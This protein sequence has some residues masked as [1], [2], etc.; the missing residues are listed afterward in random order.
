MNCEKCSNPINPSIDP[1]ISV[2]EY[3]Q[4]AKDTDVDARVCSW[5]CAY[6]LAD[7]KTWELA[8][9]SVQGKP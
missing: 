6:D 7:D 1:Y 2:Q 4:P 9:A 5:S 3:S 8:E